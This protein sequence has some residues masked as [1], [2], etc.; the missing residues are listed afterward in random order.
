M[1][2]NDPN[3]QNPPPNQGPL[4][5]VG[6][7]RDPL[8]SRQW[9]LSNTGQGG[10]TPGEDARVVGAWNEGFSGR[11]VR[12]AVVDDGLEVNHEDLRPNVFV[13]QS[14]N[15]ATNKNDPSP[16]TNGPCDGDGGN[17]DC[18]GTS[19]AGVIAGFAN[20]VG[21]RGAAPYA[22][23]VGY[24]LLANGALSVDSTEADAMQ[25][26]APAVWVSN[27]SWGK[28]DDGR[29][30][31][32]SA[33]WKAAVVTGLESGRGGLGTIYTW[34]GGNGGRRR[35]DNSNYEA[36]AN[37]RGVMAICGVDADGRQ[38]DYSDPGANLWVCTPS[39]AGNR[40]LPGV[41]TTD[42]TGAEGYNAGTG[43]DLDSAN[44]TGRFGGTSSATALAS[45]IV[46]LVLEANPRLGWRDV[47]QVLAETARRNDPS[48]GDWTKNGA[49]VFVN[50][51]YGFGVANAQA[52][53]ARAKTWTPLGPQKQFTVSG[54]APRPL[55]AVDAVTLSAN[56]SASG[57]TKIEWVEIELTVEHQ[58]DGEL[59][60]AL[61][62]NATGTRSQL[63]QARS[64]DPVALDACGN[65]NGW[66]FGSARHLNEAADGTWSLDIRDA[67][68]GQSG[69]VVSWRLI[70]Y[71]T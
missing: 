71:G 44:Y 52:A 68:P 12:V 13:S 63:A 20:Q 54:E 65:Y 3:G 67:Q 6:D 15:Y 31:T 25:R 1:T 30:H 42:R 35:N 29:L 47:R 34:A 39:S 40:P 62:N 23:L 5:P 69:T 2:Q 46:A 36:Y 38:P 11:G 43:G 10:G 51:K 7:I 33:V 37:F 26:N 19:I 21:G 49:G 60:I 41:V 28:D 14:F 9:H 55:A 18:H 16:V 56:V 27:N 45:G 61:V 48:D 59:D 64:C 8:F 57:I 4:P 24:N 70:F 17:A 58:N 22:T 66:V 53:V 50:H 32:S